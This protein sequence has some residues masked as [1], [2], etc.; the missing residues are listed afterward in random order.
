MEF[1]GPNGKMN[2]SVDKSN[3]RQV[4]L[5]FYKQFRVGIEAAKKT[6]I[7]YKMT[8]I[9]NIVVCGMGGSALPGDLLQATNNE[10]QITKLPIIVHRNYG[11]PKEASKGSLIVC[12]SYSGNTEETIS[13][14]KDA[15]KRKLKTAVIASGGKLIR[16]AKENNYPYV[17]VPGGI[18]PRFAVG[19]QFSALTKLFSKF[20]LIRNIDKQILGIEKNV[21]SLKMENLGKKIAKELGNKI[22]VIYAG[23]WEILAKIWKINFNENAKRPAFYNVLPELNHNEMIGL[24]ES[25]ATKNIFKLIILFEKNENKRVLKRIKVLSKIFKKKGIQIIFQEVSG[26]DFFAKLFS[27]VLIGVWASYYLALSQKIDPAPVNLV[28]EFKNKLKS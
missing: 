28:E 19:Y 18:Q 2:K 27:G 24:G 13:A 1:A 23:K 14:L 10:L 15:Q 25:K 3:T 9:S 22:P 4:M 20:K 21:K 16:I 5:D 17:L 7:P 8:G 12:V 6:V 26:K 11:L